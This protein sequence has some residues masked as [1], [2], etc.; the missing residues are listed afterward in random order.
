MKKT[1]G[2]YPGGA[3]SP[4]WFTGCL[5]KATAEGFKFNKFRFFIKKDFKEGK[6]RLGPLRLEAHFENPNIK[7]PRW[8][9]NTWIKSKKRYYASPL[10]GDWRRLIR[11]QTKLGRPAVTCRIDF[12][13]EVWSPFLK[14]YDKIFMRVK[15]E[16]QTFEIYRQSLNLIR[17]KIS[18]PLKVKPVQKISKPS[19]ESL[20]KAEI[21]EREGLRSW[22]D[23]GVKRDWKPED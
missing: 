7:V 8:Y 16:A 20:T 1:P 14:T 5:Q 9:W 23:Y 22:L 12:Y 4:L 2:N 19:V 6:F 10:K 18:E 3:S 15:R 13:K 21:E 11:F 17:K